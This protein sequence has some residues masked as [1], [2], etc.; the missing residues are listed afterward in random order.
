MKMDAKFV[1]R[2]RVVAGVIFLLVLSL[3]TYA[4]RDVCWVGNGYGSCSAMI[5]EVVSHGR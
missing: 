5:D 4:I 1:R 2:R 3:F